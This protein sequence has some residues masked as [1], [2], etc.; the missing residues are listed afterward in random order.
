M[1]DKA[2][3]MYE[4]QK[5]AKEMRKKLKDLFFTA[6]T[7]SGSIK[8]TVNGEQEITSLTIELLERYV[9]APQVLS[10]YIQD[11]V[12]KA[13]DKSKKGSADIMRGMMGDLG[14]G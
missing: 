9:N 2:K 8:V 13:I 12:N 11:V 4:L 3:R 1:F 10:L 5:Q 14:I 7:A 6:E